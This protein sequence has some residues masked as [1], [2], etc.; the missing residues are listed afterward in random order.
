MGVTAACD[1]L[2]PVGWLSACPAIIAA[3]NLEQKLAELK[4]RDDSAEAGGGVERREREHKQGKMSARER[5][6]FLLDAA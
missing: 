1:A 6:E 4:R 3:M 5:I 2:F